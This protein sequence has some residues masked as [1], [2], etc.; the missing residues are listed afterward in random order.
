[1]EQ[2]LWKLGE[3]KRKWCNL[4]DEGGRRHQ[5]TQQS[6]IY[7]FETLVLPSLVNRRLTPDLTGRLAE[8]AEKIS[9]QVHG[10]NLSS[11]VLVRMSK[12]RK[13]NLT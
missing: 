2:G 7:T 4:G 6:N 3:F 10:G 9:L 1:M 12:C 5:Q 13:W 8:S 11:K